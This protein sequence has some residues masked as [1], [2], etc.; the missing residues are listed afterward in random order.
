MSFIYNDKNLLNKLLKAGQ[1][2]PVAPGFTNDAVN[3]A[4]QMLANL[5]QQIS[6]KDVFTAGRD[7]ASARTTHLKDLDSLLFFLSYNKIAHNGK[8]I[9]V[10]NRQESTQNKNLVDSGYIP[11]SVDGKEPY[12]YYIDKI[13]LVAYLKSLQSSDNP[14]QNAMI[15]S[16]IEKANAKLQL[17]LTKDTLSQPAQTKPNVGV[18]GSTVNDVANPKTVNQSSNQVDNRQIFAQISTTLPFDTHDI[19]F[20]RIINF[21]KLYTTV[22]GNAGAPSKSSVFAA[23]QQAKTAMNKASSSTPINRVNFPLDNLNPA[24]VQSWLKPPQGQYFDSLLQSLITVI[25]NVE[26]VVKDF[27]NSYSRRAST[28]SADKMSEEL[29]NLVQQ[30]ILGNSIFQHNFNILKDVENRLGEVTQQGR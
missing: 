1:A 13:A 30:Q 9:V 15:N 5:D 17:N 2:K 27:Y 25:T 20:N 4:R 29:H 21:F 22:I 12:Q 8:D 14:I 18:A 24:Q 3:T 28:E 16:L 11:F 7:D 6:G 19:D 26:V 10:P 23:I